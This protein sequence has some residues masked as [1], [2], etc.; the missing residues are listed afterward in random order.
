MEYFIA[1]GV[2]GL[3]CYVVYRHGKRIGSRKG[4]RVGRARA[5]R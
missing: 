1:V 5:A 3:I 2:I 4:F